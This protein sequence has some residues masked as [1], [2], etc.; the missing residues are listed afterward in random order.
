MREQII[1]NRCSKCKVLKAISEFHKNKSKPSGYQAWCKVC[2]AGYWTLYRQ[3]P[4]PKA[5]RAA[6]QRRYCQ[7]AKGKAVAAAGAVRYRQR[8][9][10][11]INAGTAIL[12]AIASGRIPRPQSLPCSGGCGEQAKLYH[13]DNGYEPSDWLDVVAVCR[14][15]HLAAHRALIH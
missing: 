5:A 8:H 12:H 7:T 11:R 10:E 9:P 1:S 4:K 6:Y 15:C 13:H 3:T 14:E 2:C